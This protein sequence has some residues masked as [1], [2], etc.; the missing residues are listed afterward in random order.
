MQPVEIY[1]IKK[2]SNDNEKNRFSVI[3]PSTIKK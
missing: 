2:R 1:A 3:L